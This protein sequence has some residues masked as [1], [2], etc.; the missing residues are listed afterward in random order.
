MAPTPLWRRPNAML[1]TPVSWYTRLLDVSSIQT[2]VT[3]VVGVSQTSR[4]Q[5]RLRVVRPTAAVRWCRP[6]SCKRCR[7]GVVSTSLARS[8]RAGPRT[9]RRRP[10]RQTWISSCCTPTTGR[11]GI[12]GPGSGNG[13]TCLGRP[14]RTPDC[15][16]WSTRTTCKTKELHRPWPCP[17]PQ[18][19]RSAGRPNRAW[20]PTPIVPKCLRWTSAFRS[21]TQRFFGRFRFSRYHH[22]DR[23]IET[24]RYI[25]TA[26]TYYQRIPCRFGEPM[27]R[28]IDNKGGLMVM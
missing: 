10:A 1:P 20:A 9:G 11:N 28:F 12:W 19:I 14:T 22:H 8:R 3:N 4:N 21:R 26:I 5:Q 27:A 7:S 2:P 6:L 25:I 23:L 17:S 15:R 16:S 24:T 13:R 18:R